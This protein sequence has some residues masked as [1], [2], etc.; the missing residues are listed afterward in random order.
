M[1]VPVESRTEKSTSRPSSAADRLPECDGVSDTFDQKTG[2]SPK[3]EDSASLPKHRGV[4]KAGRWLQ[5]YQKTALVYPGWTQL[6][7]ALCQWMMY[8]DSDTTPS[9]LRRAACHAAFL[10]CAIVAIASD[11]AGTVVYPLRFLSAAAKARSE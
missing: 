8:G 6:S 4:Q 5:A 10:P 2:N 3:R 11:I 7:Y 1:R 9:L